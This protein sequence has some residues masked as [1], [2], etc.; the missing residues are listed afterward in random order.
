LIS[1]QDATR[2]DFPPARPRQKW[3]DVGKDA[4]GRVAPEQ[5]VDSLEDA[6]LL[7]RVERCADDTV[8][9]STRIL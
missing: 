9:P 4:I 2:D 3:D 7:V 6:L 1:T 8:T 5:G